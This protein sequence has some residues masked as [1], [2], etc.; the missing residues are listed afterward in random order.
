MKRNL[1]LQ[2]VVKLHIKSDEI[3]D[4]ATINGD[5]KTNN[6]E[7]KK[8]DKLFQ[9]VSEDI[10]LAK[11]VYSHLLAHSCITTKISSASECLK[12]NIYTDE[13]IKILEELS[14]RTDIGVRRTN[15]EMV[16]R[17]WNGEFLGKTL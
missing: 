14:K 6:K 3:I 10:D 12:L 17:V 11:E 15:A 4:Y 9:I 2:E 8:R 1:S 13:S 16:L 5:Y 7:F